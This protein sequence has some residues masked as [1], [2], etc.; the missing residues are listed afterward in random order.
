MK[1]ELLEEYVHLE[2]DGRLLLVDKNGNGPKKPV[3][4]RMKFLEDDVLRLPTPSEAK[5]M[6]I[7]WVPRRVNIFSIGERK[8]RIQVSTPDIP[9]P[10]HWASKDDTISD[11]A[12]DPVVRES[13]YRTLHRIVSKVVLLNDA[14]QVL[15]VKVTRG[16]FTGSW[17]LPGGFVDYGEHPEDGAV[18]EAKEELGLSILIDAKIRVDKDMTQK[19]NLII[20]ESI[21]NDEGLD[22]VSFTYRSQYTDNGQKITPKDGEIEE[23]RWFD[24]RTAISNCISVFDRE[25][26]DLLV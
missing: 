11:N 17:T 18:R 14:N 2:H 15:M 20:R 23:A 26:I 5:R 6:G 13:V 7:P 9:W 19:P 16:F 8:V 21:F 25:A 4:G 22:W 10:S 12:V 24:K 1:V 3:M